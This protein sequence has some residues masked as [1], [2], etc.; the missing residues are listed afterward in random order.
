ML[1]DISHLVTLSRHTPL[2]KKC[3]VLLEW[4]LRA[5][6][7]GLVNSHRMNEREKNVFEAF[8]VAALAETVESLMSYKRLKIDPNEKFLRRRVPF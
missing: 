4:P 3:H 1:R 8:G 7:D 2:P 6:N 5:N